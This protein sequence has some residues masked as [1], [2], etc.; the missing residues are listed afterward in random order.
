[1]LMLK[2]LALGVPASV[3]LA[4]DDTFREVVYLP[5]GQTYHVGYFDMPIDHFSQTNEEH[6][7]LRFFISTEFYQT[8]GPIFLYPGGQGSILDVANDLDFPWAMAEEFGAAIV[9]VEHRYYGA[10]LPYG[11]DSF[12]NTSALQYLTL[13][14]TLADYIVVATH[15]TVKIVQDDYVPIVA[16]GVGYSGLLATWLRLKFPEIITG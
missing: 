2:L 9:F 14:Q 12:Q 11:Q 8:N 4:T 6:F 1:M 10:S 3:A 15:I 5:N 7:H 16:F 13:R